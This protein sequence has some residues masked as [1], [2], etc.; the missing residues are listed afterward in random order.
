MTAECL[1]YLSYS[2]TIKEIGE[3]LVG[4][5]RAKATNNSDQT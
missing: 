4:F 3:G 2:E 1:A 5:G